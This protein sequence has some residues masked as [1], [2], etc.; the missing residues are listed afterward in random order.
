MLDKRSI[1]HNRGGRF[2]WSHFDELG[3]AGCFS[4]DVKPLHSPTFPKQASLLALVAKPNPGSL[5]PL[6][7]RLIIMPN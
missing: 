5:V 4:K 3:A 7:I 6:L 1:S 2:G